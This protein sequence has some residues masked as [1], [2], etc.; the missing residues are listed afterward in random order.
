MHTVTSC[1]PKKPCNC[2]SQKVFY[3][4]ERSNDCIFVNCSC[5]IEFEKKSAHFWSFSFE[6]ILKS[7]KK[8]KKK[9]VPSLDR[10]IFLSNSL[11]N[12]K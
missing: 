11:T 1:T 5:I 9:P 6:L 12:Y 8:V 2:R 3:L 4:P 7:R 10:E